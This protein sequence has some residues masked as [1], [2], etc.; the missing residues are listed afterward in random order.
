MF[1]LWWGGFSYSTG[2]PQ[3]DIEQFDTLDDAIEACVSRYRNVDGTTPCVDENSAMTIWLVD[4]REV[5]DPYP[6]YIIEIV[7]DDFK[8]V[9]A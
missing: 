1:G 9:P 4:P 3:T 8:V 2:D 7:G 6:D 5:V